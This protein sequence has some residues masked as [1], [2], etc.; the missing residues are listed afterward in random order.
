ML[1]DVPAV[2]VSESQ[3][4]TTP[5]EDRDRQ[6]EGLESLAGLARGALHRVIT[7]GDS[8]FVRVMRSIAGH[9][10]LAV[11]ARPRDRDGR[12]HRIQVKLNNRRG[13]TIYSRRGFLA[14]T[15]WAGHCARR[16]R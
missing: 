14:T 5:R 6:T 13:A 12:R 16:S 15:R 10:L 7:S 1:L 2:D 3:R 4:P 9:Y 8:A 11:E